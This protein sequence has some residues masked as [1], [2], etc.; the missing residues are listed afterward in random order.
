M[1][2]YNE[3]VSNVLRP[4]SPANNDEGFMRRPH[5]IHIPAYP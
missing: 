4:F 2:V 3:A 5:T 1:I